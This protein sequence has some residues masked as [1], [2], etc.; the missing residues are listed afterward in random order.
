MLRFLG[1]FGIPKKDER[2]RTVDVHAMRHSFGTL[3]SK[4][5]MAP[6]TAQAAMRHST[7]DLTMNTYTD[8]KLLDV[9]GALDA[10]PRLPLDKA[11][12]ESEAKTGTDNGARTFAP[13]FAPKALKS[14]Q[15]LATTVK[16][17]VEAVASIELSEDA[18]S[19]DTVKQKQPSSTSD[20]SCPKVERKGVEPSTS[21]LRTQR[22]PN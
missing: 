5:G 9:H 19:V 7:I 2:G 15:T 3:L 12:P 18:V 16:M 6:R 4:G 8:P 17:A 21:A 10:L 11:A 22:S 1:E 20:E 14:G 13:A